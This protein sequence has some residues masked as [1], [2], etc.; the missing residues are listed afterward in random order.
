VQYEPSSLLRG[1]L[2]EQAAHYFFE[3]VA[4]RV[5]GSSRFGVC[6]GRRVLHLPLH[7]CKAARFVCIGRVLLFTMRTLQPV[8]ACTTRCTLLQYV[9][10]GRCTIF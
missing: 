4:L 10:F 7:T 6:G 1:V 5:I 2:D 9:P 8:K 3:G